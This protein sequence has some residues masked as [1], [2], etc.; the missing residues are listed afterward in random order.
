[1]TTLVVILYYLSVA[2]PIF[3]IKPPKFEA[4]GHWPLVKAATVVVRLVYAVPALSSSA[5]VKPAQNIHEM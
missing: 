5:L 1:M 3:Y 4:T 2:A